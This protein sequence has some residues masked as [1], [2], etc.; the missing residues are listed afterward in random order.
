VD[1]GSPASGHESPH[2]YG[3][4]RGASVGP[5]GRPLTA[6]RGVEPPAR[7]VCGWMERLTQAWFPRLSA[8]PRSLRELPTFPP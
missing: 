5:C 3:Q 1:V 8:G 7:P 2:R 4:R 6:P